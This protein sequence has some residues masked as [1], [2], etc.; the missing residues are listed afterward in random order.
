[1][2]IK[3]KSLVR[4]IS[5]QSPSQT[6]H[7]TAWK[8]RSLWS[9]GRG[10]PASYFGRRRGILVAW[11]GN[12]GHR[13]QSKRSHWIFAPYLQR[14][15]SAEWL[16]WGQRKPSIRSG[17]LLPL[18]TCSACTGS[19]QLHGRITRSCSVHA[20]PERRRFSPGSFLAHNLV[21]GCMLSK[22][23]DHAPQGVAFPQDSCFSRMTLSLKTKK[24]S[25][26]T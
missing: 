12:F 16:T 24:F 21:R 2:L 17:W 25:K 10:A 7:T 6:T 14:C 8:W 11:G 18:R 26:Q 20:P 5:L 9:P 22:Y 3:K 4:K 1:M 19:P 13:Y 15:S 23:G